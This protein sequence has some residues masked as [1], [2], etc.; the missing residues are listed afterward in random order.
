MDDN[1]E[2][3]DSL[4]Q[5]IPEIFYEDNIKDITSPDVSNFLVSEV[6]WDN[7]M[8]PGMLLCCYLF[9]FRHTYIYINIGN[10]LR[11]YSTLHL[12]CHIIVIIVL[13]F[14]AVQDDASASN[15]NRDQ[16]PFDGMADTEVERKLKVLKDSTLFHFYV[17]FFI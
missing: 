13:K 15:G 7:F 10:M 16:L 11:V 14:F 12:A 5:K 1:R 3:D 4:L 2:F 8:T 6:S 17:Y 9:I